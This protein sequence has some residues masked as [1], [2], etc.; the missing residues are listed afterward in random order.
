[1]LNVSVPGYGDLEIE[2]AVFDFN[3]T[4]AAGGKLHTAIRRMMP[5][6]KEKLNVYILSS[7]TFGTV[8]SQCDGL[9]VHIKVIDSGRACALKADFIKQL[10]AGR[11]VCI[12]NGNNDIDMFRECAL[13][14]LIIGREGCS[15]KALAF[16][17][18][19]VNNIEDALN[20]LIDPTRIIATL[21][22]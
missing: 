21:R 19:V 13:A 17:D 11:T 6:I 20:L 22:G 5:E 3:G 2:N 10:G 12:G 1:M 7:D 18:I 14:V 9:G 8:V 15:A 4:L 16:A